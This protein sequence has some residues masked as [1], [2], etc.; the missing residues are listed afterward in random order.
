MIVWCLLL[1]YIVLV[2]LVKGE[3]RTPQARRSYIINVGLVTAIVVGCRGNNYEHVY[4]LTIYSQFYTEMTRIPWNQIFEYSNFEK[5][6][7]ILTKLLTCLSSDPQLL[8]F[9]SSIICVGSASIFIYRNTNYV[10]EAYFFFMTLGTLGFMLTGLRQGIAISIGLLSFEFIKKKKSFLFM[11]LILFLLAVSI[12]RS[13]LVLIA[14]SFILVMPKYFSKKI[15]TYLGIV[16]A[17]IVLAPIMLLWGNSFT[18]GELEYTDEALFSF[19]GIVP[20]LIYFTCIIIEFTR[21]KK[22]FGKNVSQ[23]NGDSQLNRLPLMSFC[24]GFY[25]LRFFNRQLERLA[26]YFSPVSVLCLGDYVGRKPFLLRSLFFLLSFIL[27]WRRYST[28]DYGNF[29]FFWNL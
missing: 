6:F 8:I 9:V 7:T 17:M 15:W 18:E 28:A 21:W 25:L 12:H 19:N 10:F 4:D 27:F 2:R 26:L 29:V 3:L 1:L 20:L 22:T 11:Y 14:S 13:S 23:H 5:G 16:I 24:I